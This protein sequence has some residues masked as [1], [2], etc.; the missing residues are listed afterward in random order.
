[1]RFVDSRSDARVQVADFLAGVARRIA[2]DDL[3]GR[4]DVRLT[5]LLWRPRSALSNSALPDWAGHMAELLKHAASWDTLLLALLIY[6]FAP[7]FVLRLLVK[8]YPEDDPR[9]RELVAE[10]YAVKRLWRPFWVADA[11][12]AVLVEGLPR[13]LADLRGVLVRATLRKVLEMR[14]H[15]FRRGNGDDRILGDPGD[16]GPPGDGWL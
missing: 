12:G 1:M 2:Y 15:K 5:G 13:R 8:L 4:G 9:R 16:F 14:L 11:L 7:G 10:L 3:N 6:G